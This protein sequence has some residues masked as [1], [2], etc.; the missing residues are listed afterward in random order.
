[1]EQQARAFEE[2][3]IWLHPGS[4]V[5]ADSVGWVRAEAAPSSDSPPRLAAEIDL[6]ALPETLW[7]GYGPR[8]GW[9]RLS[10]DALGEPVVFYSAAARGPVRSRVPLWRLTP[11]PRQAA[12]VAPTDLG[13]DLGHP[14]SQPVDLSTAL[15]LL[16]RLCNELAASAAVLDRLEAEARPA[17][18]DPAGSNGI[19]GRMLRSRPAPRPAPRVIANPGILV[20]GRKDIA[21]AQ[22]VL[23]RL[24]ETLDRLHSALPPEAPALIAAA[25]AHVELPFFLAEAAPDVP[26]TDGA[27]APLRIYQRNVPASRSA[28]GPEGA[29]SSLWAEDWQAELAARACALVHSAPETMAPA[30][31][32]FWAAQVQS[33]DAAEPVSMGDVRSTGDGPVAVLL[34]LPSLPHA[35]WDWGAD[36]LE[37]CLP[38]RALAEGDFSPVFGLWTET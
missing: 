19:W 13:Y 12:P 23:D 9:L 24:F 26:A 14:R 27:P 1:M 31:R 32:A 15:D 7:R 34:R 21:A 20:T 17:T 3:I 5:P 30:A 18:P 25:L 10:L 36:A 35:G 33:R 22:A 37:I 16:G 2:A 38:L 6:G 11:T 29:P 28:R 8:R 4:G